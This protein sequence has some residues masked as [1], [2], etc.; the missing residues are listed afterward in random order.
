MKVQ[1]IRLLSF[2]FI[3]TMSVQSSNSSVSVDGVQDKGLGLNHLQSL[4]GDTITSTNNLPFA[5]ANEYE[6]AIVYVTGR[7]SEISVPDKAAQGTIAKK[8]YLSYSGKIKTILFD[9][10]TKVNANPKET[11][12]LKNDVVSWHQHIADLVNR[13][14]A[15]AKDADLAYY[16]AK[17]NNSFRHLTVKAKNVIGHTLLEE[18]KKSVDDVAKEMMAVL[19]ETTKNIS[20]E[21]RELADK[22]S[23]KN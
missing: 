2:A 17:F 23:A 4:I 10:M 7:W 9:F 14:G 20:K 5:W 13:D 16:Q 12:V 15:L 21:F 22:E 19:L 6:I 1:T 18:T 3:V 11:E 8:G